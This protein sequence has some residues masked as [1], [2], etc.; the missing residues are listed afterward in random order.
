M[1]DPDGLQVMVM[2]TPADMADRDCARDLL[3]RLRL[4]HPEITLVRADSVYA[5]ALIEWARTFLNL[6]VKV[7][8]RPRG[9]QGFVVLAKRWGVERSPSW[10][11][12]ARRNMR[13]HERLAPEQ[14]N[15]DHLL[16]DHTDDA[17]PHPQRPRQVVLGKGFVTAPLRVTVPRNPSNERR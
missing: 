10:A 16:G 6:T 7:V 9:A 2:V 8:S 14:H 3:F 12:R 1:V 5:G 15:R 17:P 4:T 13:D 11:L